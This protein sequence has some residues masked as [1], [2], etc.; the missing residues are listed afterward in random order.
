MTNI[1]AT[2]V[3]ELGRSAASVRH[4]VN[5]TTRA[6]KPTAPSAISHDMPMTLETTLLSLV[7][8]R[9]V[10]QLER[11]GCPIYTLVPI[12]YFFPYKINKKN[13]KASFFG[14]EFFRFFP[15]LFREEPKFSVKTE[16]IASLGT[17]LIRHF[18]I[19]RCSEPCT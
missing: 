15:N 14:G 18:N 19:A 8:S 9:V 10:A 3:S 17:T 12:L 5:S 7:R 1:S 13:V 11:C 6:Q 4:F 2:A 16:I